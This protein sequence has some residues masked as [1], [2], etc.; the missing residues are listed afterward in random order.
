MYNFTWFSLIPLIFIVSVVQAENVFIQPPNKDL[1]QETSEIFS[2]GDR[3]NITLIT[4]LD[5]VF[6]LIK[7]DNTP[8]YHDSL[9]IDAGPGPYEGKTQPFTIL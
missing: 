6:I 9:P 1:E 2:L 8:D 5:V 7:T 4:D 3:M